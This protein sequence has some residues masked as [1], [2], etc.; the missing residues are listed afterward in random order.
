MPSL[1]P[2]ARVLQNPHRGRPKN[3]PLR[4]RFQILDSTFR[5]QMKP[6][7]PP[8]VT[9]SEPVGG[10]IGASPDDFQ[11]T[12][13]PAYAFDGE[14]EHLYLLVRKRDANTRDVERVLAEHF[15]IDRRDVGYA[16]MKDRQAVTQQWFSIANS[17]D[18]E[19][20][21]LA[22]DM[23]VLEVARHR[24]K[25]RRGHLSG[26]TFAVTLRN[27]EADDDAIESIAAS[28]RST[29]IYNAFG[30]QRFGHEGD[31]LRQALEWAEGGGKV[32]H[33]K[34]KF[35]TSVIQSEVF[36]RYLVIRHEAQSQLTAT[37][38]DVM[39]LDG[40]RSVFV[41]EDADEG[42]RRRQE[43]DIHITGPIFGPKAKSPHTVPKSWERKAIHDLRISEDAI[44]RLA[45]NGQGTRRDVL[46][47]ISD[48]KW[49][50]VDE[51]AIQ[52][53]FTLPSGSY[54]TQVIREFIRTPWL[55][56]MRDNDGEDFLDE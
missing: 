34:R 56:K 38:G 33:F 22:K 15:S 53:E 20:F 32:S 37:V 14:G 3:S 51:S 16:G 6:T 54:A 30:H 11:V 46:L 19:P 29:G 35:Y 1:S 2:V 45:R 39:R 24:N 27:V 12:E 44:G 13:V 36:N 21:K 31:N 18:V 55:S 49:V 42:E 8:F 48:L 28:I 7:E 4:R 26:N 10:H 50:R 25:L 52:L 23:E 9:S 43:Y 40:N 17:E 41:C 47:R 5:Q